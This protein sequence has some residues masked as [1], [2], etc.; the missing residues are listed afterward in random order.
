MVILIHAANVLYLGSYL[1]KDIL[2]LRALTVIAG[3][4]LVGYYLLLPMPLWVAVAWNFVF[5]TI[6]TWQ[7]RALLLE[8]R[9]V[10]LEPEQ[11]RLYQ[12]A[13]RSLLPREFAKLLA[14]AHW[15]DARQGERIVTRGEP[16]DRM[17]V[18]ASGRVRVELTDG[19]ALD[20]RPG[21]F[22]GEMSFIT[23]NRPN[24]DVIACEPT[25]IA[26]WSQKELRTLLE[27]SVELRAAV[28]KVI[29]DDLVAKL[30]PAA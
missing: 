18:I 4:T 25:R 16:L 19:P 2:W 26:S 22:V 5:L 14:L 27:G 6:N 30:H 15:S 10:R 11:L 23:G 12:L 20:L 29:G 13:F 1:V 17:M 9:P 24:A 8:R 21:C 7:I 28:Q 3:L